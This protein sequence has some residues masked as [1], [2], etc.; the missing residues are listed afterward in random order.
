ME[1]NARERGLLDQLEML[2]RQGR[3]EAEAAATLGVILPGEDDLLV[4]SRGVPS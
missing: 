2:I 1:L 3:S 4:S